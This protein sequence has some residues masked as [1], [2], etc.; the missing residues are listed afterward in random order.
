M[1]GFPKQKRSHNMRV[2]QSWIR[3]YADQQQMA[4]SPV[5]CSDFDRWYPIA[6]RV[7]GATAL[8]A[9]RPWDAS[10]YRKT[11]DTLGERFDVQ[12][13]PAHRW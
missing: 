8:L 12:V 9:T 11:L 13:G 10:H 7:A 2:L 3:E 5:G 1:S 4:E 6:R